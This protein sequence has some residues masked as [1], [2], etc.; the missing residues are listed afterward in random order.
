VEITTR[1]K[2]GCTVLDLNGKLVLGPATRELR[3]RVREA[4]KK[5]PNRIILN[6]REVNYADSCG[7]GELVSSYSHVKSQGGKLV[8]L[9]PP[10]RVMSLLLLTKLETVFEIFE[11][12][13]TAIMDFR[14][15]QAPHQVY[16]RAEKAGEK[17]AP[18]EAL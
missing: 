17:Y 13:Q 15:S 5:D 16:S 8:L 6:L 10:S 9:D 3:D 18:R 1:T 4:A 14:K 12:E 2:G 7:I 11:D